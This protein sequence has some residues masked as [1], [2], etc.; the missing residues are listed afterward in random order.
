MN[1]ISKFINE[2]LIAPQVDALLKAQHQPPAFGAARSA[3]LSLRDAIGQPHDFDYSLLY[4]LY[5]L[6]ADVSG[7]VHK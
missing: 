3:E 5:K 7:S 1:P 4:S 6:N 2:R